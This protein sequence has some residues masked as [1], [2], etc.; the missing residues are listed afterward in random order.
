MGVLEFT[1]P[2]GED[3]RL[4]VQ[5]AFRVLHE[6]QVLL[7]SRDMTYAREGAGADA[8]D[9]F[10]TVYDTRAALLNRV[11]AGAGSQVETVHVGEGGTL[12]LEATRGLRVEALPG[13]SSPGEE[14]WRAFARSGARYG[15]P[16][17]VI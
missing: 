11:L 3:L 16:P 1:G 13:C 10:S 9:T 4:H 6:G 12:T 2:Q 15:Y 8:F 14:A 7:G 5:C 17:E